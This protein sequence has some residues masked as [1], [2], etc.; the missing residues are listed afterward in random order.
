MGAGIFPPM[1]RFPCSRVYPW[2]AFSSLHVCFM[3]PRLVPTLIAAAVLGGCVSYEPKELT[4][5]ATQ[6]QLEQ[7]RLTDPGLERFLAAR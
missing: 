3:P 5:A 7:R 6:T 4:A 2:S 1:S